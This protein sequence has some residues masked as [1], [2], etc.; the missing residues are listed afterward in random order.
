MAVL[1]TIATHAAELSGLTAA[2]SELAETAGQPYTRAEWMLSWWKHA[3]PPSV[4][5]SVVASFAGPDLIGI[6]PFFAT[7]ERPAVYRLLASPVCAG[8]APLVRPG[9]EEE[10]AASTCAALAAL[11]NP[12]GMLVLSRLA[13]DSAWPRMLAE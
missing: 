4:D 12:P 8:L 1:T 5:L 9:A 13:E 7:R 3:A 2:W 6:A 10:V 11:P